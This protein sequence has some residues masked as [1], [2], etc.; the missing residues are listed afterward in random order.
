MGRNTVYFHS[1]SNCRCH[2]KILR[3][4]QKRFLSMETAVSSAASNLVT[5]GEI[6]GKQRSFSLSWQVDLKTTHWLPWVVLIGPHSYFVGRGHA[7]VTPPTMSFLGIF[8]RDQSNFGALQKIMLSW[9]V[10]LSPST[11][12][13]EVQPA[14]P[15]KFFW[16]TETMTSVV[17]SPQNDIKKSSIE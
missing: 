7:F 2:I 15:G 1:S 3:H 11:W 5:G 14:V 17:P 16:M 10:L 9:K 12:L 8:C 6:H 4:I 13:V